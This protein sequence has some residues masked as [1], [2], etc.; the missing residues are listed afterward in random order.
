MNKLRFIEALIACFFLAAFAF[1]LLSGSMD[2]LEA[3]TLNWRFCLRPQKE[4]RTNI[5]LVLIT[6]ECLT[7]LGTWPLSRAWHALLVDRIASAGAKAVAFDVVFE[8][9]STS[10]LEGDRAFVNSCQK[11]GHVVFPLVLSTVQVF[12]NPASGPILLEEARL[13]FNDLANAAA[14]FGYVNVDFEFLNP[15]GVIQKAFIVH[16]FENRWI[17]NFSLAIADEVTGKEIAG[18]DK[19]ISAVGPK[20]PSIEL[21]P[22]KP[23]KDSWHAGTGK[24]VYVNYPG[25]DYKTFFRAHS[26]SDVVE[27]KLSSDAFHD[28]IVMVGAVATGLGD[29]KLTPYGLMPGVVVHASLLENIIA[30]NFLTSPGV[31]GQI[32][33][34]AGISFFTFLIL[35][36]EEMFI[37]ST[38]VFGLF[39]SGYAIFCHLV[40]IR[41]KLVLPM[42]VPLVMPVCHYV[43]VRFLQL[44]ANLKR[45]NI[46]L[47]DQNLLLDQK[48]NE[49]MVLHNA[50][51]RFPEILE[52]AILSQEIIEKFCELYGADAGLIVYFDAKT[53]LFQPLGQSTDNRRENLLLEHHGELAE[54]LHTVFCEKRVVRTLDSS[55]YST[56]IPLLLG[57]LCWGAICLHESEAL[58]KSS[59]SEYFWTTLLGISCTAL[60]NSRMYEMAREVSLARQIQANFLPQ[61]PLEL[62][63]YRVFGK[64][65]PATQLGG[66]YFDYFV[67]ENRFLVVL[68]ADVM[69]HGVPAALG[70]TIVKTSVLQR[71]AEGFSIESLVNS[72]NNTLL[73][74]QERKL[75]VT[76]QF[77]L[78]DTARH[79]C[80]IHHRG[81][82]FPFRTGL[83][84]LWSQ[85]KCVVAPPLGVKKNSASPGTSVDF[86]K[87]DRWM[88]YTDGLYE[89]LDAG[90]ENEMKIQALQDYLDSRPPL[91]LV[92][93]CS[94]V[95]DHHPSYLSGKPQPDD[96]TV[97]MLERDSDAAC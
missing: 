8:D 14:G 41:H 35:C 30:Q 94:D 32:A 1:L 86:N 80:V 38:M 47:K 67:I 18:S 34:I 5:I 68:I 36:W 75:M 95:L 33:I 45:A 76:A 57:N 53:G 64:S 63:G 87:G 78:I 59:Y 81:H 71:A 74:S 72:I 90:F 49:L 93:A 31:K 97:V 73:N 9:N 19:A 69:G 3:K 10:D 6:D 89:S 58:R 23:G 82:V 51:T 96:F 54:I 13:P 11:F 20:I 22:W 62:N 56:Y 21:P 37:T 27:G 40:F 92:E 77:L 65:R 46:N 26:F 42:T 15:D 83:D 17:R 43:V 55:L 24:A 48:V 61:K 50:G 28:A 91:S 66:D 79:S 12:S 2:G 7:R 60:E 84:R 52:T 25:K 44:I 16:N 70:M 88:L 39:L 4:V 29:M 85:Q